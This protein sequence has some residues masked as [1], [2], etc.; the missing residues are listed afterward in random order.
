M[1]NDERLNPRTYLY[2]PEFINHERSE[3]S[4]VFLY[5]NLPAFL[6]Y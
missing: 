3:W 1:N 5:A 6:G 4:P 2:I